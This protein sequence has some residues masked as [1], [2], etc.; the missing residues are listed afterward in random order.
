MATGTR[1]AG[2]APRASVLANFL[3]I[4]RSIRRLLFHGRSLV[5]ALFA[6]TLVLLAVRPILFQ[7]EVRLEG[8]LA[9]MAGVGFSFA[10]VSFSAATALRE[11]RG[12]SAGMIDAAVMLPG[13][14]LAIVVVLALS[15]ARVRLSSNLGAGTALDWGLRGTMAVITGL[16]I[17]LAFLGFRALVYLLG[18]GLEAAAENGP[19]LVALEGSSSEDRRPETTR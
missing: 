6:V 13:Y 15:A 4:E 8:L 9:S 19:P 14:S 5:P 12:W 17:V 11:R 3:A 10:S 18:P 2:P 1:P 7:P 16:A